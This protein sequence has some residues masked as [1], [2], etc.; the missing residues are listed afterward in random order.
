MH[1]GNDSNSHFFVDY[2]V[3]YRIDGKLVK[4]MKFIPSVGK[5]LLEKRGFRCRPVLDTKSS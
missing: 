3:E 5:C 2:A 4:S 1:A